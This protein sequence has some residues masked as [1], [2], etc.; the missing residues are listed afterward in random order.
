M[1][2]TLCFFTILCMLFVSGCNMKSIAPAP[3]PGYVSSPAPILAPTPTSTPEEPA[4]APTSTPLVEK[5]VPY[6]ASTFT[7]IEADFSEYFGGINGCA[8]FLAPNENRIT[9]YNSELSSKRSSPC[10]TF[11]IVSSLI[12]IK[13][14]IISTENSLIPWSGE[15]YWNDDWNQDMT[16]ERA[17]KS[18]CVWYYR[19]LIDRIG[20]ATMQQSLETI[21]Y[22]NRDIS[23]WAGSLNTNNSNPDLTGFWI[24]SSLTISPEEQAVVLANIFEQGLYFSEAAISAVKAVMRYQ[25]DQTDSAIYGKTGMGKKDGKIVDAWYVGFFEWEGNTTYFAVRL[26]DPE[27]E[28]VTSA[29][30]REIA[31]SI[32]QNWDA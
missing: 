10:S 16:F 1:N 7:G 9:V 18:S 29:K 8:V 31:L 25:T 21:S 24:E 5:A 13:N 22:G 12:A 4:L 28:S 19:E 17:F 32:I 30:A 20:Q 6:D 2:K 15:T 3:T 14:Q 26:D 23:D 11:K 27:N